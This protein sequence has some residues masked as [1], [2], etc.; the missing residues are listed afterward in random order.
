[1]KWIT[2]EISVRVAAVAAVSLTAVSLT[3]CGSHGDAT[4]STAGFAGTVTVG[5]IGPYSG[6]NSSGYAGLPKVLTAWADAVNAHGGVDGY[7][8]DVVTEDTGLN[9]AAGPEDVRKL[10][11]QDHV[12]AVIDNVDN[13]DATWIPYAAGKGVPVI[14]GIPD[15]VSIVNPADFDP[16]VSVPAI[17]GGLAQNAKATGGVL[18]TTENG[19]SQAA[20][21]GK[22]FHLATGAM[23]VRLASAVAVPPTTVD[24]TA[25]CQQIKNVGATALYNGVTEASLNQRLIDTCRQQGVRATVLMTGNTSIPAWRTDPAFRGGVVEDFVAPF[26]DTAIPG[27][28][29][30]RDALHQYAPDVI[31]TASD[32]SLGLAAWAAG[33]LFAAAAHGQATP[34]TAAG[35]EQ[36]L[37]ALKGATA[38]GIVP[39]VTF[40]PGKPYNSSCYF[41]WQV[42]RSSQFAALNK[43]QPT[44]LRPSV[45]DPIMTLVQDALKSSGQ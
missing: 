3:A 24:F 12:V 23:G 7:R 27:V 9:P 38:D 44:C 20:F 22:L 34:L 11:E 14:A 45:I 8:V 33:Q 31:G 1:M 19:G 15:D 4:G 29:A 13:N 26:F 42:N 2:R 5:A 32:N 35:V 36:G 41:T 39:P 10:V 25:I 28:K 17:V 6:A 18:S 16:F 30:Y 40:T 21:A 43:A 37:Y